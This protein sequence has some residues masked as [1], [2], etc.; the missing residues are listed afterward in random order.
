MK[1][2]TILNNGKISELDKADLK[3]LKKG[4]TGQEALD[5]AKKHGGRLPFIF[6]VLRDLDNTKLKQILIDNWIWTGELYNGS[7]SRLCLYG[8]LSLYSYWDDLS[9]SDSG[10]R[11]VFVKDDVDVSKVKS[12]AKRL[13][14]LADE[15]E[16]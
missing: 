2:Y 10:G 11:V 14:K 5:L 8:G 9:D 3:D 16:V 6:E 1:Y 4:L 7:L 12:I 15:I 13:R